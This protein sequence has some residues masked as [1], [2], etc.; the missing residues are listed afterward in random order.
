MRRIIGN[1]AEGAAFDA[2]KAGNHARPIGLAQFHETAGIGNHLNGGAHIIS[3]LSVFG[4]DVAQ[5]ALVF[6]IMAFH[7]ALKIA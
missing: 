3:A 7:R 2:H 4:N 1:Q 6:A 5:F